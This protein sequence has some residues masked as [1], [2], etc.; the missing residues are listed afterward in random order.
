MKT[1]LLVLILFSSFQ[2]HAVEYICWQVDEMPG[3]AFESSATNCPNGV[4]KEKGTVAQATGIRKSIVC[5]M[6]A[7][8][9]ALTPSVVQLLQSR[10][11][12]PIEEIKKMDSKDLLIPLTGSGF[13]GRPSSIVCEGKGSIK[14]DILNNLSLV[15]AKCPGFTACA[16]TDEIFYNMSLAPMTIET[17]P[18]HVYGTSPIRTAPTKQDGQK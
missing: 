1:I 17:S 18:S 4:T 10:L 7:T 14:K 8:C 16:N 12:K 11:H 13:F 15:E 9:L 6:P 5:V 3:M 2:S